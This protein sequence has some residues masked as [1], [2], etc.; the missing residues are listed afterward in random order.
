MELLRR[1]WNDEDAQAVIEYSLLMG[2]VA[3]VSGALFLAA[4]GSIQSIWSVTNGQL[5]ASYALVGT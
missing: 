5:V 4:G 3:L 2:F 1:F